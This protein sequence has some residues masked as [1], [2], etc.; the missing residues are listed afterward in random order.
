[1]TAERHA[2][3]KAVFLAAR[4]LDGAARQARIDAECGDDE[5]LRHDVQALLAHDL[6]DTI[7]EP[8]ATRRAPGEPREPDAAAPTVPTPGTG[9]TGRLPLKRLLGSRFPVVVGGMILLALLGL[10]GVWTRGQAT[11]S[12]RDVLA[13]SLTTVL[14]ADIEALQRWVA[15]EIEIAGWWAGDSDVRLHARALDAFVAGAAD[16][17][18]QEL[19]AALRAAPELQALRRELGPV[20]E[21]RGLRSFGLVSVTGRLLASSLPPGQEEAVGM[22]LSP[23]GV[24]MIAPV[25]EGE[26]LIRMPYRLG[27]MVTIPTRW[28]EDR[29]MAVMAPVRADDERIVAALVFLFAPDRDFTRILSV[30]RLGESGDTYAFDA[31]GL[32]L[33]HSRF[34]D[35]IAAL[36]GLEANSEGSMLRVSVV[37]PGG[38]P[39]RMAEQATRQLDGVD[40]EGYVGCRGDEVLGAWRWLPEYD[41]GVATEVTK[42][43]AYRVIDPVQTAFGGLF[44]VLGVSLAGL[45]L[46]AL[47]IGRLRRSMRK[48]GQYQLV[49]LIGEGGMGVVYEAHHRLLHRPV[50]LKLLRREVVSAANLARFEREVQLTAELDNPNTIQVYDYGRTDD[51]VFY[52]VM[53]YL[54]GISLASLVKTDGPLPSARVAHVLRQVCESLA[55]AHER[56]LV[57]RDVKPANVMLCRRGGLHDVVKVLDF[58]LV[59]EV[60]GSSGKTLTAPGLLAGTPRYLAPELLS[61]GAPADARSDLYALGVTAF[62]L[63]TGERLF[64]GVHGAALFECVVSRPAPCPSSRTSGPIPDALDQLVLEL[65]AKDPDQR[66]QSARAVIARL[67][68]VSAAAPWGEDRARAWWT[69]REGPQGVSTRTQSSSK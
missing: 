38:Q 62:E 12:L 37:G 48:L 4:E 53:E 15:S 3:A 55:E 21:A 30:A 59:K 14:A 7:L 47:V 61:S 68:Q 45:V 65:L 2:R 56:G 46:T 24:A 18:E 22:L 52:Y 20:L 43:E 57:H 17:T 13:E 50:A 58:G 19:V 23:E 44:V 5:E 8:P 63:L 35:E 34:E 6:S 39:T 69:T 33:S 41:I 28:D 51:G 66:P 16:A 9:T 29:V 36:Q 1:M 31:D 54:D 67:E 42:A 60:A 11:A 26:S 25:F 49:R 27:L 10:A 40:T 32:M 64:P